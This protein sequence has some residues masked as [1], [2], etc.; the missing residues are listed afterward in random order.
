MDVDILSSENAKCLINKSIKSS[1]LT[2][3]VCGSPATGFNFSVITCMCCKAFFRRNALY[4]LHSYQ[5]RYSTGECTINMLTRRDCSYCRLKKCFQ[6]GMKKELILT[7]DVKRLKR[8]KILANRKLTISNGL[9]LCAYKNFLSGDDSILLR[10]ISNVYEEHCRLPIMSYEKREYELTC[11]QP[12]KTRIKSQHYLESFQ[13]HCSSLNNFFQHLPDLQEFSP[14]EQKR[15]LSHNSRFLMRL[16][17][18]ETLDD[19]FPLWGAA[20]LLIEIMYGKSIMDNVDQ[21]L[22]Q[23]RFYLNDSRCTQLML[24]VLL[25]S[26]SIN[27]QGNLNTLVL[28]K[29]QEKYVH[30]LWSYLERRYGSVGACEKFSLIIRYCL[31]LQAIGHLMEV[32]IHDVQWQDILLSTQKINIE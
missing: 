23:V 14:D 19:S 27:Y 7:D 6:V 17:S 1:G 15:L 18:V 20:R 4:G 11:Q 28:Y 29:L 2:C 10:N 13:K 5:C 8:E 21:C 24:I 25:F 12:L 30:L 32:K 31:R 9:D 26:T 16:N 22:H 3:L